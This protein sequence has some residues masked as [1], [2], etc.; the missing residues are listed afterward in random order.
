MSENE[1]FI[2]EVTEQVRRDKLYLVLKKYGWIGIVLIVSLV[3]S[4][5]V[6]EIRS[7]TEITAAQKR[8]DFLAEVLNPDRSDRFSNYSEIESILDQGSLVSSLLQAWLAEENSDQETAQKV[9]NVI[10]TERGPNNFRD[11][12]NFKLLLLKKENMA[13]SEQLLNDLISPGNP[14]RLLALEQ[15]VLIEIKRS[16][17]NEAQNTLDI[18]TN[19]MEASEGIKS[20]AIQ[21]QNAITFGGSSNL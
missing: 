20:R 15:K 7:N 21:I 6:F 18:L 12:A 11:F 5:I 4:S 10:L 19:D 13:E 2:N 16:Q 3:I 8:G 1:S 17:W 9:Y 14:F